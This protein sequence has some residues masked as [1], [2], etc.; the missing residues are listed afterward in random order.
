MRLGIMY[1][2]ILPHFYLRRDK[3]LIASEVSPQR[4]FGQSLKTAQLPEKRD[5]IVFCPLGDRQVI[6]YQNLVNSEGPF[7]RCMLTARNDIA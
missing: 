1:E 7:C 2:R 6:A 3:R 5:M 4:P